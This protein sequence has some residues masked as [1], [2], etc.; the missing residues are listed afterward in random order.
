[1]MQTGANTESSESA[2]SVLQRFGTDT[3]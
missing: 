3:R 2:S 1:M